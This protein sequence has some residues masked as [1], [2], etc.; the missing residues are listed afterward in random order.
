MS[1]STARRYLDWLRVGVLDYLGLVIAPFGFPRVYAPIQD[2]VVECS[3]CHNF[4]EKF[5]LA[6]LPFW[7]SG[8]VVRTISDSRGGRPP[9]CS[10]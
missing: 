5:L 4:S 7:E 9:P 8:T 10:T 2:F 3:C 1:D 6:W